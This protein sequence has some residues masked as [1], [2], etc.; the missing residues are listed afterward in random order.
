MKSANLFD[1]AAVD[2]EGNDLEAPLFGGIGEAHLAAHQELLDGGFDHAIEGG[3]AAFA[4]E[5]PGPDDAVVADFDP[6][7]GREFLESGL[8]NAGGSIHGVVE[9]CLNF[10]QIG[11]ALARGGFGESRTIEGTAGIDV[12]D[13]A[14]FVEIIGRVEQIIE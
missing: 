11:I 4:H 2:C 8:G 14:C 1:F 3:F 9:F 5:I 10:L 7:L 13:G 12:A 6:H